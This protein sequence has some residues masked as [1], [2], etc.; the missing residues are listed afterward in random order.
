MTHV[1]AIVIGS[2]QGGVPFAADLAESGKR[3]VLVE[4]GQLGGSC[5]N[6]GCTPSK[7][8][9]AS[10]HNAGRARR[11]AALGIKVTAVVDFPATMDRVRSIRDRF[12]HNIARR[13]AEAG[14]TVVHAQASFVR[15]L[16]VR[17]GEEEYQAP[18]IV[19]DTGTSAFVPPIEG[20]RQTPYLTNFT[21]FDQREL[22]A[23]MVVLG[24]GYIG[25][26]LGQGMA[27][28]GCQVT[29]VDHGARVLA[30]EE[31][32][33][34]AL[35]WTSLELDG[36]RALLSRSIVSVTHDASGFTTTLDDGTR[37]QS[38]ALLV[39]TGRIPN[40]AALDAPAA[41]VALDPHGYIKIDD[42]FATSCPGVYAVGDVA[43]QPQFT[44]VAWEDYR[45]LKEILAGGTRT[46]D[47]R[48]LGYTTFTEPQV[49]RVG[50]D[51]G[52]AKAM[53]LD[54]RV[55]TLPLD[56][57]ARA[58]EWGQEA[59]F[60]RLVVDCAS[61]KILGATLVGYEAGELVHVILAHM[62][63]GST[64]RVLDR[65]MHIHPTYAEGLPSLARLLE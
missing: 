19:I 34:G 46:R 54:A 50:L 36:V 4:R 64:W 48:V 16:V 7:A 29:I 22:P 43:G 17:A 25:L 58:V 41:G 24:G 59:G 5:I 23:S 10:A 27:R 60:Y 40:T 49:A 57:V 35:L 42:R 13:L 51:A 63:A 28:S 20:L 31:A 53:G 6:Y 1:D 3:V 37:L 39:A 55:V 52:Q 32:D 26:E 45:R 47:D 56:H 11:A 62:E 18:L 61:E 44:H 65:S 15:P 38:E 30:R 21:F 14:V 12:E 9:L 2:G 8:F 33:A